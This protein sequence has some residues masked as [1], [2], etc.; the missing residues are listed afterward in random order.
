M[1]GE[2]WDFKVQSF[3]IQNKS[4]IYFDN[5]GIYLLVRVLYCQ[6]YHVRVANHRTNKS[7]LVTHY[8]YKKKLF[9]DGRLF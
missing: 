7:L 6:S 9:N 3:A 8:L 5:D 2:G 1:Y 4:I